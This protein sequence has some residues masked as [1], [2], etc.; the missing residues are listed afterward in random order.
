[1]GFLGLFILGIGNAK[2]ATYERTFTSQV[3][4]NYHSSVDYGVMNWTV[5]TPTNTSLVFSV[6]AGNTVTPDSS[7]TNSNSFATISDSGDSLDACD[8]YRYM[9]YQVVLGT[10]D[11]SA[12]PT[13]Y[14]VSM[15]K[16]T[17][18][19]ISSVFDSEDSQNIING[20]SWDETLS[21]SSDNVVF[22]MR[23]SADNSTWTSWCGPDNGGVGCDTESWFTDF[24]GTETADAIFSDQ[25]D[26]RY[27]QYQSILISDTVGGNEWP[28]VD[29]VNVDYELPDT[30]SRTY[31]RT[32]TSSIKDI[33]TAQEYMDVD[34]SA[35]VLPN[36]SLLVKVRT[37]S[38]SDMSGATAWASCD[39]V[40]NN[41]DISS[42]DCV[43]D[44]EQYFEYQITFGTNDLSKFPT[45]Y[46]I[47]IQALLPGSLISSPYNSTDTAN[48]MGGVSWTEDESSPTGSETKVYLRTAS[49]T[50]D[51]LLASWT[52]IA[53]STAGES[54]PSGCI[55]VGQDFTCDSTVIPAGMKDATD[56]RYFQYKVELSTS[57]TTQT[58]EQIEIVYVVNASP[59]FESAPTATQNPDGTVPISYSVR[60]PDTDDAGAAT[61]GLL[62]PSL[63][64][65]SINDGVD[66]TAVT[67]SCLTLGATS[68]IAVEEVNY[69]ANSTTWTP[70]CEAGVSNSTYTTTAMIRVTVNDSEGANN[71]TA[72]SSIAFTLD[73]TPPVFTDMD[74]IATTTPA[75]LNITSSDDSSYDLMV[76]TA[77]DFTG[78][79]WASSTNSTTISISNEPATVYIK[80]RDAFLNTTSSYS[81]TT[82]ATP[83]AMMV[84]DTSNV[85]SPAT[86][87]RL[88][89]AWDVV[90]EPLFTKYELWRSTDNS[91]Y[92][93]L[94]SVSNIAIN[95][96]SDTNVVADTSYY[97]KVNVY[98][99]NDSTSYFTSSIQAK[100]NGVQDYGEGGGGTEGSVPVI[101]NVAISSVYTTQA[102]ITWDTDELANSTVGYDT[103]TSSFLTEVGIA[104]MVETDHSITLTGLTP[105]N[106][107]Y[108][109]VKSTD[110]S[111]NTASSTHNTD[112][113]MFTT[114]AGPSIAITS[115][116]V[117]NI[118]NT[119]ARIN[120]TT[121]I[122]AS[123]S[124]TYS[125]HSDM[126]DSTTSN[127]N[128]QVTDHNITLTG[129]S[130][131]VKY[132]YYIESATAR[133]NN[134][135][136]YYYFS[137]DQDT[138]GPIITFSSATDV[139]SITDTTATVNWTTDEPASSTI[140]W[141]FDTSYASGTMSNINKNYNH[142]FD[143]TGLTL[144]TEYHIRLTSTDE[145][146]NTSIS[147]DYTFTTTDSTDIIAPIIT[148]SPTATTISDTWA[149]I[150]WLTNEAS[151]ST[152]RYSSTSGVYTLAS[153]TTSRYTNHSIKLTGLTAET[154]YYFYTTSIDANSN[155]TSSIPWNFTTL[156]TQYGE[157]E[158]E[159]LEDTARTEGESSATSPGGGGTIIIDKTDKTPP[160]ISDIRVTELGASSA[161]VEWVTDEESDSFVEYGL[162]GGVDIYTYGTKT[163]NNNHAVKLKWLDTEQQYSYKVLSED[164]WGN[165]STSEQKQFTTLSYVEELELAEAK[166]LSFDEIEALLAEQK[167]TGEKIE[168]D[169]DSVFMEAVKK[170]INLVKSVASEVSLSSLESTLMLQDDAINEL[171]NT[172][173]APLLSGE[174]KVITTAT[175]VTVAWRTDKDSNSLVALAPEGSYKVADNNDGVYLQVVGNSGDATKEHVVPIY[176]LTPDTL[177]HYQLRSKASIGPM[178][179]S[180]D[181]TFKTQSE[182]IDITNYTIE[183]LSPEEA[184]FKWVTNIESDSTIKYTPYRN[185][186]LASDESRTKYLEISTNIHEIGINNL[187][188]GITYRIELISKDIEGNQTSET[189][190]NFSTANDDLPPV[191]TQVQTKSAISP[192]KNTKVQTIITWATN[193]LSTSRVYFQEGIARA[194]Q[195]LSDQTEQENSYTKRH[196]VVI[197]KFDP[198]KVYSFRV[199]SIDSGG[200]TAISK[201]YTILTP[202]Q[203]ESVFQVIMKNLEEIFGWVGKIR[204]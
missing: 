113:Y 5:D 173:P 120:W 153:S 87:Y 201:I 14:D 90:T 31:E 54:P 188:A 37:D 190:D 83:S 6:K 191:I 110:A 181:F 86:D 114:Q 193:E 128:T 164:D 15:T 202:R 60:D 106:D 157:T 171:A 57:G 73:T 174:P 175:G 133:A 11:L 58:I 138:T 51:L 48:T 136:S 141:G 196:V 33:G 97:Y 158:V 98:D 47:N 122:I 152:V 35:D 198:G 36:T 150:T 74:I 13:V 42:N 105:A 148:I 95:Y 192:G 30:A 12:F 126:S 17:N 116:S 41:T 27:Y 16:N 117:T 197:T 61:P 104:T 66:W 70:T 144:G 79:S 179:K 187:E 151:D 78:A 204:D 1:M 76:S 100:A 162:V 82:P 84:Q 71:T 50:E 3:F 189:I 55:K 49:S 149:I 32:F 52:E 172:I 137:T 200:N 121:D 18:D 145:N 77:S 19:L 34:W 167:E 156:E 178:A 2:A 10:D 64:E 124:V 81:T 88:F 72:S 22:Q 146:D 130:T 111:G 161:T 40:S 8:G 177:Y 56:D 21:G 92:T 184:I 26:D 154:I 132:Y 131:G 140:I 45:L 25:A 199:E 107:Y 168:Q 44:G 28:I 89:V 9:Q 115:I 20:L 147:T 69:T 129:L 53:S 101:S 155:S 135:G 194:D 63:F 142:S 166:E 127:N 203:Q 94:T 46:D 99:T 23:T 165:L 68:S 93:L 108:F 159:T 39:L 65:Y 85:K 109:R 170:A 102:T 119:G 182:L 96:Y 103:A 125:S 38:A 7:W 143:L 67:D 91:N 169:K 112:G 139:T 160:T 183:L 80:F 180:R 186:I 123:S 195:E 163:N 134:S 75:T 59:E 62:I 176:E 29:N 4:D 185:N 43:T 118:T 24:N